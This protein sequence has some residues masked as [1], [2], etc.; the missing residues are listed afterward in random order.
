VGLAAGAIQDA[1]QIRGGAV[2]AQQL[3]LLSD[4]HKQAEAAVQPG[5]D[6]RRVFE[7]LVRD[8]EVRCD[9]ADGLVYLVELNGGLGLSAPSAV[10]AAALAAVDSFR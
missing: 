7:Q 5:L 8:S 6:A 3:V 1:A 4:P 9:L 10:G 2:A